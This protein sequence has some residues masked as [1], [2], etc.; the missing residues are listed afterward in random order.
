MATDSPG[1]VTA[2]V[3]LLTGVSAWL[4]LS[5]RRAGRH[6]S[7]R[8]TSEESGFEGDESP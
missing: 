5:G 4:I 7:N 3:F 1:L 8:S 2:A 6:R